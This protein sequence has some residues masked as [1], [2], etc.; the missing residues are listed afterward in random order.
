MIEG[1]CFQSVFNQFTPDHLHT[2]PDDLHQVQLDIIEAPLIILIQ[3]L[4]DDIVRA[5]PL[6]PGNLHPV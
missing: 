2:V 3:Q 1:F 6:L 5:S 4:V